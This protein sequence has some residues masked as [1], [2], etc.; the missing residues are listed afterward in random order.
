M[1]VVELAPTGR[2]TARPAW[3]RLNPARWSWSVAV[4]AAT[5]WCV[6]PLWRG[7]LAP[8]HVQPVAGT[9]LAG[10]W[11]CGS[12][13]RHLAVGDAPA[14]AVYDRGLVASRLATGTGDAVR[15]RFNRR[16]LTPAE[17]RRAEA[18]RLE[19][20]AFERLGRCGTC[21]DLARAFVTSGASGP[22][23]C[24]A[25][26]G[27]WQAPSVLAMLRTALRHRERDAAPQR[28]PGF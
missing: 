18:V 9:W 19:A 12:W 23:V 6:R 13:R 2:D 14:A 15:G 21:V 26:G 10:R 28:L 22:P 20:V 5:G 7:T 3:L 11:R 4:R 25:C 16:S 27:V 17:R 1:P 8:R 24:P